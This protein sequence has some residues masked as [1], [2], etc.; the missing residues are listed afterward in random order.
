VNPQL[1]TWIGNAAL[2]W[3]AAVGVASVI[4]FSRVRWWSTAIGTHLMAYQSVIA[5]VLVLGV[6]RL[7]LGDTWWFSLLR[8]IVFLCVPI[9]MTQRLV[10]LIRA[11]RRALRTDERTDR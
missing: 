1:L 6:I 10:L 11:Q 2:C 9:V 5:A 8:L 4:V 3:A 7:A